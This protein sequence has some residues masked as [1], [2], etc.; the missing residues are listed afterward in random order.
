MFKKE[1]SSLF[2]HHSDAQTM[3]KT[4]SVRI[5]FTCEE[6]QL[7]ADLARVDLNKNNSRLIGRHI[8]RYVR[9]Q[10]LGEPPVLIH[11]IAQEQWA[12]LSHLAANLNQV[13]RHLNS[14][15]DNAA[16]EAARLVNKIRNGLIGIAKTNDEI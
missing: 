4:K 14:G 12:A 11:P 9:D 3:K 2:D 6:Y 16:T 8:A 13:S 15:F 7:L 10:A 1:Q 5:W